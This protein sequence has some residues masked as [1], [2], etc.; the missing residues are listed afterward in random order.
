MNETKYL[1]VGEKPS[2]RAKDIKATWEKA[3]LAGKTLHDALTAIGIE[4]AERTFINLFGNDPEAP[5]F[6]TIHVQRQVKRI[7]T[8]QR[9]GYVI[10]GMGRNVQRMLDAHRVEHL[11]LVHPAARGRIRRKELYI[12]HVAETLS[13]SSQREAA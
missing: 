9:E 10:V 8:K 3:M 2:Q 11:K 6:D 1:F 13:I 4:E 5:L 12:K 7:R